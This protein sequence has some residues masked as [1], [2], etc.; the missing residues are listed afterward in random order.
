MVI[1]VPNKSDMTS[2]HQVSK[3]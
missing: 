2:K 3:L 1:S